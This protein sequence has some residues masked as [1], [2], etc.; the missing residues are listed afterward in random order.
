MLLIIWGVSF[1]TESPRPKQSSASEAPPKMVSVSSQIDPR[2]TWTR[3]VQETV[4]AFQEEITKMMKEEREATKQEIASI[5]TEARAL[6]EEALK[7]EQSS[8]QEESASTVRVI[9]SDLLSLPETSPSPTLGYL[10]NDSLSSSKKHKNPARYVASG[11]FARAVLLTGVVAE[12]G[13]E[14]QSAPQPILLRLVDSGIFSKG[15]K[16]KAIKDA[17]I[18]GSCY[19]VLSS[20]RALCRLE[21]VSLTDE[22]DAVIERSLEGWVIGEDGRPG[23]KGDVVDKASDVARMAILNGILGG[24]AGFFQNQAQASTFPVSPI[25]GAAHALK[26]KDALKAGASSGVGSA[27]TKLADYA[28]KR[29]EQMNPVI[30]IGAG[31]QVDV[32]FRRGFHIEDESPVE[33]IKT[34]V[35]EETRLSLEEQKDLAKSGISQAGAFAKSS[36]PLGSM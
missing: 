12:T 25:S 3:D 11:A 9:D 28:I 16:T 26:G 6:M 7:A 19:G 18:I 22:K 8:T 31:R 20:E 30:L 1:L 2:D 13:T 17:I 24:I 27:L 34:S 21:S 36:N 33:H 15:H 35:R 5:R 29:A 32:V 10:R 14:S 4:R 23:L